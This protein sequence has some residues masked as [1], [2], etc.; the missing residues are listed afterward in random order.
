MSNKAANAIKAIMA[1]A[2]AIREAGRIPSGILYA[3]L[4]PHGCSLETYEQIIGLLTDPQ[5]GKVKP[6][7]IR[8]G[9]VLVWNV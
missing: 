3:M 7:V 2:D 1:V 4:S 5:D 6:L 9:N 8:E